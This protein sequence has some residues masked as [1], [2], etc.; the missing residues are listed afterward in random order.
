[1]IRGVD[2]EVQASHWQDIERMKDDSKYEM[3]ANKTPAYQ[4]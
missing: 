3:R 4:S 2:N 1:M